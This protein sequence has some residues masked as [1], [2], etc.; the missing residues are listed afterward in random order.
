MV[1]DVAVLTAG[2][3][4]FTS[5]APW[6]NTGLNMICS[7]E[8][9]RVAYQ[10]KEVFPV[11]QVVVPAQQTVAFVPLTVPFVWGVSVCA[12]RF[13]KPSANG[14]ARPVAEEATVA[15]WLPCD[16]VFQVDKFQSQTP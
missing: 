16:R 1:Q 5:M 6:K 15:Y 13:A 14:E 2:I 3:V 4:E 11:A 12:V 10:P 9:G 8:P 7:D